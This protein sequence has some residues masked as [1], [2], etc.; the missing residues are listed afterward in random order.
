[1]LTE[2]IE[3]VRIG[4]GRAVRIGR[5][6]VVA[7]DDPPGSSGVLSSYLSFDVAFPGGDWVGICTPNNPRS[8][9]TDDVPQRES[10]EESGPDPPS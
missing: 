7:D 9:D 3:Q 6:G 4:I 5:G 1:M 8:G 10:K 2:R